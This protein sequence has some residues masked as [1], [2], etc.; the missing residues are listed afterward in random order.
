MLELKLN[1]VS[2]RSNMCLNK[3]VNTMLSTTLLLTSWFGD[4]VLAKNAYSISIDGGHNEQA[5]I[6][7]CLIF[8]WLK[9]IFIMILIS[10]GVSWGP[11]CD[12]PALVQATGL[13][14]Y[15]HCFGKLYFHYFCVIQILNIVA[16]C[17]IFNV[18]ICNVA[19]NSIISSEINWRTAL[20]VWGWT[21]QL[22]VFMWKIIN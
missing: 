5:A 3:T 8:H 17:C 4:I 20:V 9:L 7:H 15:S 13:L 6:S 10:L 22:V 1:H 14:K 19:V 12:M 2:K 21:L 16:L 18:Y 11:S